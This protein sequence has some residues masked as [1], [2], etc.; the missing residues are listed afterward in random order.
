MERDDVIEYSL[1]NH[2]SDEAGKKIRKKIWFV[3]ILLSLIT[4]IEVVVGILL[5][6]HVLGADST[7]WLSIKIFYIVLTLVKAGYIILVFMHLGEERKSLKYMI[8]VPY[9]IFI[10]YTMFILFVE[11]AYVN[12]LWVS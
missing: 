12:S 4:I 6:K 9:I 11:G 5:P 1:H 7:A 10:I 3:T 8:L 2:H